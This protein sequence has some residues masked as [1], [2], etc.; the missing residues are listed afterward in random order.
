[1]TLR[2]KKEKLDE[3]KDAEEESKGKGED[4]RGRRLSNDLISTAYICI[5]NLHAVQLIFSI[6][7]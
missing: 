6:A 4:E 1:M 7:L 3:K 5:I 2:E